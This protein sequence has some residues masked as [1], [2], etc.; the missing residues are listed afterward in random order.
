[1]LD[2]IDLFYDHLI[3]FDQIF[4]SDF[5]KIE[6]P[7]KRIS[8]PTDRHIL[9]LIRKIQDKPY[10]YVKPQ[11]RYT[12]LKLSSHDRDPKVRYVQLNDTIQKL[13]HNYHRIRDASYSSDPSQF[14]LLFSQ[15]EELFE[16]SLERLK[17]LR[18]RE[19]A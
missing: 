6:D 1:M 16:N 5:R 12:M 3:N 11:G 15:Y 13:E 2:I 17:R 7:A 4:L 10:I 14:R 19:Q 8:S 18:D 9:E